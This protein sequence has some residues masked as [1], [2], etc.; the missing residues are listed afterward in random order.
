MDLIHIPLPWKSAVVII[1][2]RLG[3]ILLKISSLWRMLNCWI[4]IFFQLEMIN[5]DKIVLS[6]I[7]SSIVNIQRKRYVN[8]GQTSFAFRVIVNLRKKLSYYVNIHD[9]IGEKKVVQKESC[10]AWG[11]SSPFMSSQVHSCPLS[12]FLSL[13]CWTW[14]RHYNHFIPPP[15]HRKLF[16]GLEMSYSQVEIGQT[17]TLLIISV[18]VHCD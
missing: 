7:F 6:N 18:S 4:W 13:T 11:P 16:R 1:T 5:V 17:L 10:Q 15:T 8:I 14:N 3:I 9:K 12:F 2:K